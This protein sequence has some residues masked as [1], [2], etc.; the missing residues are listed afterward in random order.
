MAGIKHAILMNAVVVNDHV[1]PGLAPHE[2]SEWLPEALYR[3]LEEF[4]TRG[5]EDAGL[6]LCQLGIRR[7]PDQ[8]MGFRVRWNG[9]P[10]E[11]LAEPRLIP[12]SRITFASLT[13]DRA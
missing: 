4:H 12:L 6:D 7:D 9:L 1:I 8:P 2:T 13:E 10:V 5:G 11:G 3:R